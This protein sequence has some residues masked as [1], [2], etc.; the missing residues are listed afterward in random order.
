VRAS[1]L[2]VDTRELS[3][4]EVEVVRDRGEVGARQ[5][6]LAQRE[7]VFVWHAH[8]MPEAGCSTVNLIAIYISD[9]DD[10]RRRGEETPRP[11]LC[12]DELVGNCLSRGPSE[13]AAG[14]GGAT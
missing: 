11:L 1:S 6:D 12:P 7:R 13:P 9:S 10:R 3:L 8:G 2:R 5:V 4:D 14:S